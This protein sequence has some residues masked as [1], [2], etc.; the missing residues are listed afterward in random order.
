MEQLRNVRN[1]YTCGQK[2][3]FLDK[4]VGFTNGKQKEAGKCIR[5]Q[6]ITKFTLPLETAVFVLIHKTSNMQH[7]G[8]D[9]HH[10]VDQR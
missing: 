9:H 5:E 10:D 8:S 6:K 4:R 7:K 2:K 3:Y 1:K